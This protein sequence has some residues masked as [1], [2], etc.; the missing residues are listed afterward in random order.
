METKFA[1]VNGRLKEVVIMT[2]EE[3]E[4]ERQLMKSVGKADLIEELEKEAEKGGYAQQV[5]FEYLRKLRGEIGLAVNEVQEATGA[6]T[7]RNAVDNLLDQLY[8]VGL[9][10]K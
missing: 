10:D 5:R 7:F 6:T 1:E 2:R 3:Y 9:A 8:R 4:F